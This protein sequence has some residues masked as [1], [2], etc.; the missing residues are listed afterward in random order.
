V[1]FRN[2]F[3]FKLGEVLMLLHQPV[4]ELSISQLHLHKKLCESL[5]KSGITTIG[6][7]LSASNQNL[8]TI[9]RVGRK[10]LKNLKKAKGALESSL[11]LTGEMDWI[12]YSEIQKINLIPDWYK[13]GTSSDQ[14]IECF[15]RIIKEIIKEESK[16]SERSWTIIERRFALEKPEKMT[17]KDLGE[18]LDLTNE[19]VRQIEAKILAALKDVLVDKDYSGKS[20][21]VHPEILLAFDDLISIVTSQARQAILESELINRVEQNFNLEFHKLK[22]ELN[23]LFSVLGIDRVEFYNLGLEP[24]IGFF[25]SIQPRE[26]KWIVKSLDRLLTKN[27]PQSKDELDILLEINKKLN[28]EKKLSLQQIHSCISLCS[29]VERRLDNS[30]WGKFE[31]LKSRGNQ[32]ERL[33]LENGKPMNSLEIA[34][35]IDNRLTP[36]GQIKIRK[37]NVRGIL[38]L[39]N[40][41]VPIGRSGYWI[42]R[43]WEHINTS[44]ILELMEEFLLVRNEPATVDEIYNYV[45]ERRPASKNSILFYFG[46]SELSRN[47]FSKIDQRN[48]G[49]TSWSE[50]K[51]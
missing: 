12:K 46:N 5:I 43:I 3:L 18:F 8:Q 17:L 20:Y 35:E 33:L 42:L 47:K 16:N 28:K 14:I 23:L 41:F 26:I 45:S 10:S 27:S 11:C 40:R 50:D 15:T 36:L 34:G 38:N 48:W 25:D 39:D 49:L 31:F 29:S 13:P 9:E 4:H 19:R 22:Q 21:R 51:K 6:Q 1:P 24:I 7:L 37:I 2:Q 44:S 30:V 32:I